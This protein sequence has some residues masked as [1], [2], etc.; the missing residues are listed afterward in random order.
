MLLALVGILGL[1]RN[2]GLEK[3]IEG[4]GGNQYDSQATLSLTRIVC[5]QFKSGL[6]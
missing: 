6:C 2:L 4:G 1:I 3:R 5:S